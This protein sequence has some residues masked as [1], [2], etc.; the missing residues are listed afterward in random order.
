MHT[1]KLTEVEIKMVADYKL[2]PGSVMDQ[3][4]DLF[5]FSYYAGGLRISDVLKLKWDNFDEIRIRFVVIKSKSHETIKLPSEALE[6]LSK[7]NIEGKK[8]KYIF[9]LIIEY[10]NSD[11]PGYIDTAMSLETKYLNSN[12]KTIA[13]MAG[14]EKDFGYHLSRDL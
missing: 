12:L 1:H 8:G 10:N 11:N 2:T 7:Y 14:I 4:R 5:L 9:P 3:H 13:K 6:I